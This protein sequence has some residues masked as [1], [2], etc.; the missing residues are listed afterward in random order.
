[1]HAPSGDVFS[2]V[3]KARVGK[4]IGVV[5]VSAGALYAGKRIWDHYAQ[6]AN[7]R[8]GNKKS[9]ARSK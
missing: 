1:V 6:P 3:D 4:I 8:A 2:N 9:T 7:A 5:I